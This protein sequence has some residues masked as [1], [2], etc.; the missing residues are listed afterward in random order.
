MLML[1]DR[2]VTTRAHRAGGMAS[3][4][5]LV[6]I[7]IDVAH[8]DCRPEP[9]KRKCGGPKRSAGIAEQGLESLRAQGV[10]HAREVRHCAACL[11]G[12]GRG[13]LRT[14]ER[15]DV[16]HHWC[17]EFLGANKMCTG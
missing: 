1:C 15:D 11:V 8:G 9:A 3:R 2:T 10:L 5:T 16:R 7:S 12:K 13:I 17:V 14:R 6:A 4:N